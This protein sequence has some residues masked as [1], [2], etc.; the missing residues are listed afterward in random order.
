MSK[1]DAFQ[2]QME[3]LH[4]AY[5]KQLPDKIQQIEDLWQAVCTGTP[6]KGTLQLIVSVLSTTTSSNRSDTIS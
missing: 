3:A 5:V 6:D 4:R 2:Q 1:L